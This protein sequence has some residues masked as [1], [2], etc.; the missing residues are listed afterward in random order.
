MCVTY[1]IIFNT[2]NSNSYA[3]V[4]YD[5]AILIPYRNNFRVNLKG[6]ET[7]RYNLL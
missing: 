1:P 6:T 5:L 2:F 7:M 4:F 3:C